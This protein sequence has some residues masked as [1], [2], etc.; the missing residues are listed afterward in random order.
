LRRNLNRSAAGA[1]YHITALPAFTGFLS[2]PHDAKL[3]E[4]F[5]NQILP[6]FAYKS[7]TGFNMASQ[8]LSQFYLNYFAA[9]TL[10]IR[11]FP[12]W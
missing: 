6:S 3:P 10:S 12:C 2:E 8:K 11:L 5:A 4:S 7:S 1:G 9:L